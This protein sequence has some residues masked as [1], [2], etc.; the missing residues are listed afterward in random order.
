MMVG[1]AQAADPG[2][3]RVISQPCMVCHGQYGVGAIPNAP[4]IFGQPEIY[5][6]AQLKAYRDKT[7]MNEI[8]N[9][10][11]QGLSDEDIADLAAWYASIAF[12]IKPPD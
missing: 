4:N 10:A 7:R 9:V 1:P 11:A 3:G 6:V 12:E 8:M 5:T 2:R